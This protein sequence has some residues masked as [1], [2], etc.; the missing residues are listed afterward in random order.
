MM[1]RLLRSRTLRGKPATGTM[2]AMAKRAFA[3]VVLAVAAPPAVADDV[4][5]FYKGKTVTIAVGHEVGTGFDIYARVLQRHL[6]RHIPGSPTLVVQNMF[7]VGGVTA[8]NWLYNVAPKDGTA[9]GSFVYT[10][11]LEPLMGNNAARFDPAKFNWIGNMEEGVAVCGLSKAAGVAAFEQ[12]RTTETVIGGATATGALVRSA[13]AVRNLLGVKMKVVGGYKGTA[14]I[15]I[16]IARGEVH[17]VCGLLMSTVTSAWR[18]DYD[19]GNFRPIIQLSGRTRIGSIPSVDDYAKSDEDRQVHGLIFGAQALGKLYA[20][21]PDIPAVR[22]DALRAALAATMK[23]P[24]FIADAART[25]IDISP[26]TGT[27]VEAFVAGLTASSP[28][29]IERVKQ[30]F[31]P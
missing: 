14:S 31:A 2:I 8:A 28:A 19:A 20:A 22:R 18:D 7:G 16:A 5:D 23:D 30:A 1:R 12:M 25:Q 15:K 29:I 13:L 3:A 26:M 10:V 9:L 24:A 21:P 11:P 27:E 17:G 4:A 6:R